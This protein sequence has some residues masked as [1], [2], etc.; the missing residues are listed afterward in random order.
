MCTVAQNGAIMEIKRFNIKDVQPGML[1]ADNIYNSGGQLIVPQDSVLTEKAIARMRFHSIL[2][3]KIYIGDDA[4]AP[5]KTPAGEEQ[6]SYFEKLRETDEFIEY[7]DNFNN[8]LSLFEEGINKMIGGGDMDR[9]AIYNSVRGLYG[10]CRNGIQVFDLLHCM[11]SYDDITFAHS[12]NVALICTV[13]GSWLG[14]SESDLHILMECGIYHDIGK[15]M[16]PKNIVEKPSSLTPEEF[17]LMKTH[18]LRGYNILRTKDGLDKRIQLGAIMHHERCDGSGYPLGIKADQI[19][20]FSKILAIADVYEAMTSPR[21]YRKPKCPFE[22]IHIFETDG[23]SLYDPGYLMTFM[24]NITQSYL[25]NRVRL[26]D[27]TVGTIIYIN[28][29][30]YSR[31]MIQVDADTYIDLYKQTDLSIEAI[32]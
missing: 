9:D 11:R 4:P 10:T 13:L 15:L 1:V 3:V 24:E 30:A 27:G 22:V 14:Y 32:L 19:D 23:L 31:P 16:I 21:V 29:N 12:V 26:T 28:K 7:N 17:N 8:T 25:G 18:T 2:S 6:R 20:E 5:V